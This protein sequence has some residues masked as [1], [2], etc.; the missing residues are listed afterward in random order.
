MNT[1]HRNR[2]TRGLVASLSTIIVLGSLA[3]TAQTAQAQNFPYNA[4][5]PF[6]GGTVSATQSAHNTMITNHW[7]EWRNKWVTSNGAGGA[8]K[9]RVLFDGSP[10]PVNS[11]DYTTLSTVSEGQAYGM[12]F[13]V[14]FNDQVLFDD[15]Y[16][17]YK[18]HLNG[19][20]LMGWKIG[21]DGNFY[22]A[23]GGG[24]SATDADEDVAAALCFA[25]KRW[26]SSNRYTYLGEATTVIGRLKQF[27][28]WP[29]GGVKRGEWDNNDHI[30][31]ASYFMPAWYR[32]Y[33][34]VTGDAFWDT[35]IAKGYATI[36]ASA[37]VTTGLIPENFGYNAFN[38]SIYYI[39]GRDRYQYDSVRIPWRVG[40]DWLWY[41]NTDGK[42]MA[43]KI[44]TYYGSVMNLGTIENPQIRAD[45]NIDGSNAG[46]YETTAFIGMAGV[47]MQV[48]P[49]SFKSQFTLRTLLDS[50]SFRYDCQNQYYGGALNL[51]ASMTMTG[52]FPNLYAILTNVAP[53]NIY[54]DALAADWQDWSWSSTRNF[55]NTSPVKNGSKSISVNYTSNYGGLSL[56]KGTSLAT[57][58]YN[59]IKFWAYSSGTARPLSVFIQ[60]ADTGGDSSAVSITAPA[61]TWTEFTINLSSLGNPSSIKRINIQN[62]GTGLVYFDD[63]RLSQ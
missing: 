58:G 55:N 49:D 11:G 24:G 15:L 45:R 6:G 43:G 34:S 50:N 36:A 38:N 20:G 41:G 32:I 23:D 31:N 21:Y 62:P 29:D 27:N 61:N 56:R 48:Q 53:V 14:Y 63:I 5:Y 8:G 4:T 59:S 7:N 52:N 44:G 13:A 37:N 30:Y 1:Q 3:I 18:A 2:N 46:Q 39:G 25:H 22:A 40:I 60:T 33:K 9:R 51:F 16:A 57:S 19:V 26:T 12:L 10:A 35:V 54:T 28:T 47:G 42:N 17:Y